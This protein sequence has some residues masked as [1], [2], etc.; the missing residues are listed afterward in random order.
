MDVDV[1]GFVDVDEYVDVDGFV[2][3][4]VDGFVDVNGEE[5][6]VSKFCYRHWKAPF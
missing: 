6:L 2:D 3:V 1:G 4:D 5:T